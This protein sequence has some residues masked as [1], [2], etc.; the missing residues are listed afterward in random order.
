MS[1]QIWVTFH[2]PNGRILRGKAVRSHPNGGYAVRAM[3]GYIKDWY[4]VL[5]DQVIKV[6]VV[7]LGDQ[8]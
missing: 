4:Q 2:A 3:D 8:T 7:G 5:S 6:E 1:E